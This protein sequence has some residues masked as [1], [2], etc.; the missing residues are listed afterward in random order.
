MQ[1]HVKAER[2]IWQRRFWEHAI[3]D[4]SDFDRHLDYIH[5]NPVKH[6]LVEKASDWPHSSFHRFIRSGY[7]PANWAAQLELNGLD[8]D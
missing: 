8:W 2:E 1:R 5:Y 4:Q 6:G 7:Y 3:R